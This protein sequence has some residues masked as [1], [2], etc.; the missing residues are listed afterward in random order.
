MSGSDG[1]TVLLADVFSV[2]EDNVLRIRLTMPEISSVERVADSR[3]LCAR[4]ARA[5]LAVG[6]VD[7]QT[8]DIAALVE[9]FAKGASGGIVA[10]AADPAPARIT[11]L[12][13]GGVMGV[14]L[15]SGPA[16]ELITAIR[17]VAAGHQF[18]PPPYLPA[19]AE[20]VLRHPKGERARALR[21]LL[22]DREL[23]VLLLVAAGGANREIADQ[24]GI[25]VT[26]VRSHVL[27]ILRK[28]NVPN[29]TMAAICAYRSGLAGI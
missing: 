10:V 1:I 27:S 29:R 9:R 24:L 28:L 3:Q 15:A 14:V 17:A 23:D 20:A 21:S 6:V 2:S 18:V 19:L 12:F 8:P 26:T 7:A 16:E 22:T 11:E 13:A 4:A 25:S 5:A